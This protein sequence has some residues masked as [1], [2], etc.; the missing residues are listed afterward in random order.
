MAALRAG[1]SP[2]EAAGTFKGHRAL[3]RLLVTG[4][5]EMSHPSERETRLRASIT[6]TSITMNTVK[7]SP[8]E[9][10]I[11]AHENEKLLGKNKENLSKGKLYLI[12]LIGD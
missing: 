9:N 5:E 8:L 11:Q 3:W 10:H 12:N 7:E 6:F 2:G 4:G 1:Q